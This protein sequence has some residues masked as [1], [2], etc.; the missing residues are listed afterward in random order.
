MCIR[1]MFLAFNFLVFVKINS[2]II[3]TRH[4]WAE[5][6]SSQLQFKELELNFI[7]I[8]N[9]TVMYGLKLNIL[10]LFALIDTNKYLMLHL[11]GTHFATVWVCPQVWRTTSDVGKC[12]GQRDLIPSCVQWSFSSKSSGHLHFQTVWPRDL[13]YWENV[14][15]PPNVSCHM[16]HNKPHIFDHL[17]VFSAKWKAVLQIER[18]SALRKENQL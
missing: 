14:H 18:H 15:L 5:F 9:S 3:F 1:K 6:W 4:L 12:S 17:E 11:N 10:I 2:K 16:L 13:K 7:Y 8:N